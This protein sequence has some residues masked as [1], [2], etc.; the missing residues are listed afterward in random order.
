MLAEA[1][2]F[3]QVGADA[4]LIGWNLP[5]YLSAPLAGIPIIVQQ[6]GGVP[7]PITEHFDT[8]RLKLYC[9]MG[10]S[11]SDMKANMLRLKAHQDEVDG[12]ANAAGEN[13]RFLGG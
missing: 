3:R 13:V 10:L 6:P 12:P 9:A 11:G 4:V 5:S 1:D 2:A 7:A 8:P